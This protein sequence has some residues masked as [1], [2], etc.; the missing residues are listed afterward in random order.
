MLLKF[1]YIQIQLFVK[2]SNSYTTGLMWT[3]GLITNTGDDKQ[4]YKVQAATY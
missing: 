4:S 3:A 1:Q 2:P